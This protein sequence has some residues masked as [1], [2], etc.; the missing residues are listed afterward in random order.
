MNQVP[1]VNADR[2]WSRLMGMAEVCATSAGG[3]NRQALS[4]DDKAG[5]DLF[6]SWAR[7]AG[8]TI[9]LDLSAASDRSDYHKVRS[10]TEDLLALR[11]ALSN[12]GLRRQCDQ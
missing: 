1:Q 2:L 3:S 5:R 6:V 4:D 9:A 11:E 12:R 7:A 10:A 8:Y